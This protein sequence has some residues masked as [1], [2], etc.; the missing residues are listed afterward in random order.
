MNDLPLV[1]LSLIALAPIAIVM[2]LLVILRWPAKNAM[3]IAYFVT[4]VI[5]FLVWNTSGTQ[6]AAASIHGL[7]TAANL[8]FIVFGAILLLNTLKACGDIHAI[9]Q[10]FVDISPDRRVQA[11]IIAWL[12]G[13]FIEGAA[14][15]GA[16]AAIAAP[17]LVAIGFPAMA[18]VV[19]ALI[20]QSAPVS[21]GAVGTPIL[22]GV[23]TGLS[24]QPEVAS[25]VAAL[26]MTHESYLH[27]IGATVALLHG[28][29]GS[30]V[31]LVM[32]SIMTKFFGANRSFGEGLAIWKFALFAGL[33]FTIPSNVLARILGPEFPSL[34]G[35][36]VGLCL[37]VPATRAGLFQPKKAWAFPDEGEW[38]EEW[39][40]ELQIDAHDH[41]ARV[42]GGHLI[43]AWSPYLIVA[44]LLV[45]TR[46][47]QP[48]KAL[49][50]SDAVTISWANIFNSGVG[51]KSQPL[52]LPGFIFVVTVVLCYAIFRMNQT[53]IKQS[54]G[55]SGRTVLGAA[56]A[57]VF[58]V[59]MVQ[60][61]INSK[62]DSLAQ[63]PIV[64]ADGVSTLFGSLWPLIA[65]TIGGLGAF[66]AGSNTISN[67]LFSFFQFSM[68]QKIGATEHIVVA[69][70]AVGG[71]AGNMICVH[72]VV[73][74][75]ATVGLLGKEGSVI[76]KTLVPMMGYALFAGA[77]GL[78]MIGGSGTSLGAILVAGFAALLVW[79]VILGMRSE[80]LENKRQ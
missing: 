56:S 43:K 32:V 42:S 22:V 15:F 45:V 69:L 19:V 50:T 64:L 65:P 11:I 30:L 73:F 53:Q 4:V 68:A 41:A 20:I 3:P 49:I 9:R 77:L 78:V 76:R 27:L 80:K 24:G 26:G 66:I 23:N 16:P 1:A 54:L 8:L 75:S 47:V 72:N 51:T 18:A 58:A 48:V 14:G 63:M 67:M 33:A 12:F 34:L 44:A 59:P 71:A 79:L 7:V 21:F 62:S 40:G 17:L 36:L 28:I 57:L 61:F 6:I 10:G 38:D 52:Y 13:S 55:E 37:V 31:P 5:A 39:K 74:A 46:T 70:Q 2:L 60:V 25:V 29:V 35:A